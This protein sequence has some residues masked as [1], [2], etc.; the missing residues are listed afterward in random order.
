MSKDKRLRDY[1]NDYDVNQRTYDE[2]QKYL[3]RFSSS[4]NPRLRLADFSQIKEAAKHLV[5]SL[6][7]VNKYTKSDAE[8]I[9]KFRPGTEFIVE[10]NETDTGLVTHVYVPY[11][12]H[13]SHKKHEKKEEEEEE[14]K[15]PNSLVPQGILF[16]YM[17]L[18]IVAVWKTTWNDWQFIL[19]W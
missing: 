9:E 2:F 3:S 19:R 4:E 10:N 8:F 5:V 13:A 14:R 18:V 17:L 7:N 1:H 11:S 6:E 15:M 12:K 16:G